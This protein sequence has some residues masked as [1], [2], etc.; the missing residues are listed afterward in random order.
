MGFHTS[1]QLVS[2]TFRNFK[3]DDF[4]GALN[5]SSLIKLI[6]NDP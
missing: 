1:F 6:N 3:N 2:F 4:T 5:S